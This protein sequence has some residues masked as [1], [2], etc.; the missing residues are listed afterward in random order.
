MHQNYSSRK[1]RREDGGG[2]TFTLKG[3]VDGSVWATEKRP[4]G[5]WGNGVSEAKQRHLTKARLVKFS[6]TD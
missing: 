6:L 1:R 4:S 3:P 2:R 5:N